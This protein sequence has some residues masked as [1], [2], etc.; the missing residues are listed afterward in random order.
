MAIIVGFFLA[1]LAYLQYQQIASLNWGKL[2][3]ISEVNGR[4]M[5]LS[6]MVIPLILLPTSTATDVLLQQPDGTW[7]VI[8]DNPWGNRLAN[9]VIYSHILVHSELLLS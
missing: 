9:Q 7:L 2:Q 4:S 1:T 8:I 6:L 5:G 3:A